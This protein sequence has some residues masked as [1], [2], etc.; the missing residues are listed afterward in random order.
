MLVLLAAL[1]LARDFVVRRLLFFSLFDSPQI[2]LVPIRGR[3]IAQVRRDRGRASSAHAFAFALQAMSL[4]VDNDDHPNTY[5][6]VHAD[7]WRAMYP[8]VA[9]FFVVSGEPSYFGSHAS[10]VG[11]RCGELFSNTV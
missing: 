7:Q 9:A 4:V 8:S 5:L 2:P 10:A 3:S 6:A 11:E 1:T